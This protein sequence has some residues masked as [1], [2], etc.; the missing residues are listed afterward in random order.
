MRQDD[1]V[2]FAE[3]LYD[4]MGL[5][6]DHITQLQF[7]HKYVETDDAFMVSDEGDKQIILMDGYKI[8]ITKV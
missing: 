2:V 1:L 7:F 5:N 6:T 8:T 4:V 3:D